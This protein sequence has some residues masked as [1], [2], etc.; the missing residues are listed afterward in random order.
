[1]LLEESEIATTEQKCKVVYP[2]HDSPFIW[3][4]DK[5]LGQLN[6]HSEATGA[7]TGNNVHKCLNVVC[8]EL[9]DPAQAVVN[10]YGR[11][12][13]LFS[14]CHEPFNSSRQ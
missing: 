7:S 13:L 6:V 9:E 1:M 2:N 4:L 10:E 12:L 8:L 5:T 14:K 3:C 11:D